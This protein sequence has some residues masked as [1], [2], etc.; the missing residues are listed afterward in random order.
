LTLTVALTTGQHYRAAC[1][2]HVTHG[3]S[4]F[5]GCSVITLQ[6]LW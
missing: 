6:T 1:D 3:W 2:G 5:M 4:E